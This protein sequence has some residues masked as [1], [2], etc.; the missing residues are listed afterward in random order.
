MYSD[1]YKFS[2]NNTELRETLPPSVVLHCTVGTSSMELLIG[3][4]AAIVQHLRSQFISLN[5]NMCTLCSVSAISP[6][7]KCLYIL[8]I[9]KRLLATHTYAQTHTHTHTNKET[10]TKCG[11]RSSYT[12]KNTYY[13]KSIEFDSTKKG[14]THMHKHTQTK[15]QTQNA[16]A[17]VH[18]H[19]KYVL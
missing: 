6:S 9:S 19:V 13:S 15:K 10:N 8:Q 2:L 3:Y 14:H 11:R 16:G 18:I 4:N 12:R 7:L 17:R 5:Q 1:S